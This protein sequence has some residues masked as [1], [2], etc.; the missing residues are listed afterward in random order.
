MD[1][2]CILEREK[3]RYGPKTV[4]QLTKKSCKAKED[5]KLRPY[6]SIIPVPR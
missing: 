5:S 4:K 1:P 2:K 3:E 6:I